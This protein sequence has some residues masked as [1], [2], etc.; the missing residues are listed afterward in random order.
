M[1]A[2]ITFPM[3]KAVL[4]D[5]GDTVLHSD[6]KARNAAM[7]KETGVSSLLNEETKPLYRKVSA[8]VEKPETLFTILLEKKN[9]KKDLHIVIEIYKKCYSEHSSLNKEMIALIKKVRKKAKVYAFSNTNTIHKE[10]NEKR[11][12]FAHFDGAFLSCDFGYVKPDKEFFE[13]VLQRLSL[14]AKHVL[15]IDDKKENIDKAKQM[16]MQAL[17]YNTSEKL[18][19][20]LKKIHL[21]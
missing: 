4:F 9:V 7:L 19:I 21:V 14:P 6:W 16:G 13:I 10:V 15:L 17:L 1:R 3:I 5:L 18:R 12:V 8:G 20:Q 11:G 2:F